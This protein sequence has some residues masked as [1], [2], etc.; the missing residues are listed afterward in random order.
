VPYDQV[1]R[2]IVVA[3]SRGELPIGEWVDHEIARTNAIRGKQ[4]DDNLKTPTLDLFWKR[5][6]IQGDYPVRELAERVA[7]TF[8]G[9]RINCA[10]CHDHPFDEW[11]QADYQGFVRIFEQVRH[12]MSPEL[13]REMSVRLTAR[14]QRVAEGHPAGPPLP[15]LTE[16]YLVS[17]HDDNKAPTP[18]P[19]GGPDIDGELSDYRIPFADWMTS[20]QNRFFA[21]NA[22]NRAWAFYFG[23]GLVEPLDGLTDDS[24]SIAYPKLLEELAQHFSASGYDIR[25]LELLILNSRTWQ[26]SSEQLPSE[27]LTTQTGDGAD[28]HKGDNRYLSRADVR[29][30]PAAVVVDMW[31]AATGIDHDFGDDRFRGRRAVEIGPDNLPNSRWDGFQNLFGRPKRSDTCDCSPKNRPSVRQALTLMSDP[32][33]LADISRGKLARLLDSDISEDEK[34]DTLF[35]QTLSRWPTPEERAATRD[36]LAGTADGEAMKLAWE[37]VLWS[38]LNT[39][40]F[41]TIH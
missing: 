11:S 5:N 17:L 40:E 31:H 2:S 27:Q 7:S 6:D 23:R 30:P 33:L 24:D 13:R 18:K 4:S 26:L 29:L 3:R 14:R 36:S 35:L 28:R 41:I 16:V 34:I 38:L 22:V 25:E 1:V 9:V 21:R 19:L 8:L 32:R 37:N 12:D 15:R 10:R 39:Q 20:P